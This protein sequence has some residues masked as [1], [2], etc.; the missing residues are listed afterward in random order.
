MNW[1]QLNSIAQLATIDAESITKPILLLKH[2]TRCSIS[3]MALNRIESSW[4]E[5]MHEQIIP[6]YLDLIRYREVSNAIA[7]KY[8]VVHESPQVLLIK[9]GK[10]IYNESHSG[11][12]LSEILSHV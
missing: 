1:N 7:E 9:E 5:N 6:Y 2:S 12:R 8:Q 3:A 4:E 10:C 11:I